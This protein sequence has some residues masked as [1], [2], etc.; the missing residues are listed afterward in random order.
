MRVTIDGDAWPGM[1]LWNEAAIDAANDLS[2]DDNTTRWDGQVGEPHTNLQIGKSW[3]SGTLVAG[4]E[5]RYGIHY[6]NTG[7][8]PVGPFQI[9]DTLPVNTT[10]VEAHTYD[11]TPVTLGH[12]QWLRRLG[13]PRP[14]QRLLRRLRGGPGRRRE[15]LP[16]TVLVNTV[17]VT[18]LPGE[19]AY[20]D[21]VASVTETLFDHGPNLRVRKSGS[22]DDWGEGTRRASYWLNVEN[23]GDVGTV[24]QSRSSTPTP[25]ECTSTAASASTPGNGPTGA[26]TVTTSRPHCSAS[27]RV[28]PWASTSG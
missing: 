24:E 21:N 11:G 10:F 8:I 18:E 27:S 17:E 2:G 23:V 5:L 20:D 12:W 19:G 7:N 9:T 6:Q 3:S 26:T 4:G 28:G 14:G 13:L 15:A 22:W 25:P 1:A 16:G